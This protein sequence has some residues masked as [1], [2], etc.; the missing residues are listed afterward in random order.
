MTVS[1]KA[2]TLF[3]PLNPRFK[4]HGR[5]GGGGEGL[6]HRMTSNPSVTVPDRQLRQQLRQARRT[7]S[8]SYRRRA[9]E[10]AARRLAGLS[11]FRNARRIAA[12]LATDGELDPMPLVERA[13]AMG[14][15]VYLPVLLPVGARRLWFAPWEPD[16]LLLRNRYGIPEPAHAAWT[17]VSPHSLDLVLTPLVG[18]DD[19]GHRLGMGGGYYDRTF[20][21]LR[22]H[23]RWRHPHLIGL[24]YECQRLDN[25]IPAPW[26]VPLEG[27]VTEANWYPSPTARDPGSRK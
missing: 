7:L 6:F 25:L 24:A 1:L 26:D 14:K 18:F 21:F 17:R 22:T 23:R 13:W 10:Q 8:A 19:R 2:A 15:R 9:A 16:D 4:V 12:Y 3:P 27:V 11:Y 5:D 20:A